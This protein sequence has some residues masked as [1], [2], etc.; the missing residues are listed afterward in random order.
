M[1]RQAAK[2][3]RPS[4]NNPVDHDL[5]GTDTGR[6][7]STLDAPSGVFGG[8]SVVG[9]KSGATAQPEDL[10]ERAIHANIVAAQ[11]ELDELA[12]EIKSTQADQKR[13]EHKLTR[14]GL[15]LLEADQSHDN[16]SESF[17]VSE[18][19]ASLDATF[20][21]GFSGEIWMHDDTA[22]GKA[23]DRARQLVKART[24][25]LL[26]RY[27]VLP[28]GIPKPTVGRG[29]DARAPEVAALKASLSLA[30]A[31]SDH[32]LQALIG[33][34]R[35]SSKRDELV[36][37]AVEAI[38]PHTG[39]ASMM[40]LRDFDQGQR[41]EL[42]PIIEAVSAKVILLKRWI[43]GRTGNAQMRSRFYGVVATMNGLRDR[44]GLGALDRLTAL[45]PEGE[46]A[47]ER[48]EGTAMVAAKDNF[49]DAWN[50]LY[51]AMD[52][53]V[54]HWF[55]LAKK[56]KEHSP[57]FLEGLAT[58]LITAALGNVGGLLV[59]SMFSVAESQVVKAAIQELSAGVMTDAS[60][61][62][63][64]PSV[65]EAM[66]K[67]GSDPDL[68]ALLFVRGGLKQLCRELKSANITTLNN[69]VAAGTQSIADV[70]GLEK[71]TRAATK[72]ATEKLKVQSAV[73][74]AR[75]VAQSTLGS[76]SQPVSG[77]VSADV[78]NMKNYFS[79]DSRDHARHAGRASKR[80]GDYTKTAGVLNVTIYDFDERINGRIGVPHIEDIGIND[81]NAEMLE[82]I[83]SKAKTL[84]DV[85]VPIELTVRFKVYTG[86]RSHYR[87][88]ELYMAI[89]ER[90]EIRDYKIKI[91]EGARPPKDT[92]IW[93]ELRTLAPRKES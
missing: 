30:M 79:D 6:P 39:H 53:G 13:I 47:E 74:W 20:Q 32:H 93:A 80:Y 41:T 4:A 33:A 36:A 70:Q 21:R 11:N 69:Q 43:D 64:N 52:E 54:E 9:A 60:Q 8:P 84:G 59:K 51:H 75:Y 46:E 89:D 67:S 40:M 85:K 31:E 71:S 65:S 50:S 77:G 82:L 58:A 26:R 61:A 35:D 68:K 12:A 88:P 62:I 2:P 25:T 92:R 76:A 16:E 5:H 73:D 10:R 57:S 42:T 24:L 63:I 1:G 78:T 91:D 86:T 23:I 28:S 14:A 7:T 49:A 29:L 18:A 72:D 19:I 81:M 17:R 34:P 45:L 27:K 37:A 90:G 56:Q 66:S 55:E 38:R 44:V 87:H 83:T 15:Y 22:Q 3:S 48:D